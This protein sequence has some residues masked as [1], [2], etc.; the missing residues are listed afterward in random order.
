MPRTPI[1]QT[2]GELEKLAQ[3]V[4]PEVKAEVPYLERPHVKLQ[5]LIVEIQKLLARRD[6]YQALKQ[7]ATRKAQARIRQARMT[8][9]S[10]RLAL[11]EHYGP[12]SEQLAAF[13]IKPFRG[14]KRA[15][16]PDK[17]PSR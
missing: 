1:A 5:G 3:S 8:A 15:E 11:K 2:I 14:R 6:H 13:D 17:K 16:K 7:D 12:E 9:T 10:L 4:T